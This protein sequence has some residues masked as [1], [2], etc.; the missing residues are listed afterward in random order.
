MGSATINHT[1]LR[2]DFPFHEESRLV[3][4]IDLCITYK[5]GPYMLL[6]G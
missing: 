3:S 2:Q 4:L 6:T 5:D 1:Y